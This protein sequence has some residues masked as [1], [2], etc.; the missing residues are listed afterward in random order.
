MRAPVPEER[1]LATGR[2]PIKSKRTERLTHLEWTLVMDPLG[3]VREIYGQ[4]STQS[5]LTQRRKLTLRH[6]SGST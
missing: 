5:S 1:L 3:M 6:E 4:I 2:R